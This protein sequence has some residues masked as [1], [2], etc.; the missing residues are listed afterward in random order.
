MT[1]SLLIFFLH[2]ECIVKKIKFV[3]KNLYLFV[4]GKGYSSR[5]L[6]DISKISKTKIQIKVVNGNMKTS[7]KILK[8]D[9]YEQMEKIKRKIKPSSNTQCSENEYTITKAMVRTVANRGPL[10]M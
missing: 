8:L 2:N 5:I 4:R 10:S 7:E 1:Q 6:A 3:Q 9:L